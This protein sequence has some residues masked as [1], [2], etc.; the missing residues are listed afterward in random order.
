MVGPEANLFVAELALGAKRA[1]D[2]YARRAGDP[3]DLDRRLWRWIEALRDADGPRVLDVGTAWTQSSSPHLR[4]LA[5][6]VLGQLSAA[7]DSSD[8]ASRCADAVMTLLDDEDAEVVGRAL[9]ALGFLF[10][11]ERPWDVDPVVRCAD[12]PEV[13]V[14]YACCHALGGTPAERFPAALDALVR[15]M[16]DPS[17]E[18]RNWAV[19]GAGVLCRIDRPD[20]REALAARLDDPCGEARAEAIRGLAMRRDPRSPAAID[21]ALAE[22]EI[23]YPVIEA[24][25]EWPSPRYLG[26]LRMIE[27]EDR[28]WWSL[29]D[30]IEACERARGRARP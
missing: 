28:G 3:E 7:R 12:H 25:R 17:D 13:D 14:R 27:A 9:I 19:F 16:E 11:E 5:A 26:A 30:T 23:R 18:V 20:L 4:V 22:E 6:D 21:A 15:L 1:A 24:V 8:L 29:P 2:A 10:Q